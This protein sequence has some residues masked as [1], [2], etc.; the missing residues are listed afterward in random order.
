MQTDY[1][2][3][4]FIEI[5]K[6]KGVKSALKFLRAKLTEGFQISVLF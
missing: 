3:L 4:D 2:V 1:E 5:S 6:E